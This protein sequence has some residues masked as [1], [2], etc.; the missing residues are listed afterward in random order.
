MAEESYLYRH[1]SVM[2]QD[3]KRGSTTR[4]GSVAGFV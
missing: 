2:K 1:P 4:F 3:T